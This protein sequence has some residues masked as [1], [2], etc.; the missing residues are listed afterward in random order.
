[1]NMI[2]KWCS[3]STY[4]WVNSIA[5]RSFFV[6]PIEVQ[7]PSRHPPNRASLI[8]PATWISGNRCCRSA[9]RAQ[10]PWLNG[11]Y[12]LSPGCHRCHP[13]YTSTL[14]RWITG[15]IE[16]CGW[17]RKTYGIHAWICFRVDP[18]RMEVGR[19]GCFISIV[20]Y[21]DVIFELT[22]EQTAIRVVEISV[23]K[24]LGSFKCRPKWLASNHR[25]GAFILQTLPQCPLKVP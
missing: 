19:P 9:G 17:Y 23:R 10:T 3:I 13:C 11:H 14:L 7:K 21:W 24:L 8:S 18:G 16:K 25:I 5:T 20:F 1:M 6:S 12:L 22:F 2:Y 15:E 4:W